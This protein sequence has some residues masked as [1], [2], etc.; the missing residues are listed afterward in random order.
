MKPLR[1]VTGL[2]A[3]LLVGVAVLLVVQGFSTGSDPF[4]DTDRHIA[5]LRQLEVTLDQDLLKFHDGRVANYDGVNRL[6]IATESEIGNLEAHLR[7]ADDAGEVLSQLRLYED[8]FRRKRRTLEAYPAENSSLANSLRL[9]LHAA[10]AVEESAAAPPSGSG[11][12]DRL[13]SRVLLYNLTS[14][15]KLAREARAE[16]RSLR[17]Q[18]AQAGA[19]GADL[20]HLLSHVELILES[21]PRVDALVD[22]VFDLPALQQLAD[23][24]AARD[25]QVAQR[26]HRA[27]AQHWIMGVCC[28]LLLGVSIA[29]MWRLAAA[30]EAALRA[31][32]LED[33]RDAAVAA[34]R[35][36]SVFL[37]TMSHELRTPLNG[38]IGMGE[39][40]LGTRLDVEQRDC[41][42][43]LMGSAASLLTII[44]DVL[45]YSK[46]E[47]G[48]MTLEPI[49]CDLRDVLE[50]TLDV[51]AGGTLD[52]EIDLLASLSEDVPVHVLADPGRLRQV[53]VNLAGNALK[54]TE[55]GHVAIRVLSEGFADGA[56]LVR[57]RVEDTGIGIPQEKLGEIFEKFTQADNSTTRRHGGT[58]LG[59]AISRQMVA[60]MGGTLDVESREGAGSCFS[61]RVPLVPVALPAGQAPARHPLAGARALIAADSEALAQTAASAL[62]AAGLLVEHVTSGAAALQAVARGG[63]RLVLADERLPDMT[64]RALVAS[65]A[66]ADPDVQLV[67]L[68]PPGRGVP[69]GD[70]LPGRVNLA[71]KPLRPWRLLR[72]LANTTAPSRA[73]TPAATVAAP[74]AAPPPAAA[75]PAAAAPTAAAPAAAARPASASILVVED[76]AVNQHVARRMLESFGCTVTIAPDGAQAVR[77]ASEGRFDLVLMDCHMPVMDGYE[78]TRRLRRTAAGAALPIVAMTAEAVIGDREACLQAGMDDYIAKPVRREL[79]RAM[80]EKHLDGQ[81]VEA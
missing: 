35:A 45:D 56:S 16:V 36:K 76:N 11:R 38:V 71:A 54:F 51:L 37:A 30:H 43:T 63:V 6:V 3:F 77:A 7:D 31:A 55:R 26:L 78:A 32:E 60:L 79:L 10:P 49:D 80:L 52:R 61:F 47:A 28:V 9:L 8:T 27:V 20:D 25:A 13:V 57:F 62:A 39:L 19:I 42:Q 29:L 58:G 21:K 68:A 46:I 44:S 18:S 50:Q 65:L 48:G 75:A 4:D 81:R 59:L 72:T 41:A 24:S 73:A 17:D 69:A 70:S 64:G 22:R 33:A 53:L 5:N 15:E 40:L 74:P 34:N 14:D 12:A 1:L 23:L 66:A 2:L 67:L